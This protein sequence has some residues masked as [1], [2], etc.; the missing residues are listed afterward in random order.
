MKDGVRLLY[1]LL[2]STTLSSFINLIFY[3]N[4]S[5]NLIPYSVVFIS[6]LASFLFLFQYRLL[7][8]N[9]FEYYRKTIRDKQN[10]AIFGAGQFGILTK[11]LIDGSD[12]TNYKVVAFFEDDVRKAGKVINGT[13]IYDAK[14][15]LELALV[16]L[17]VS[18]LIIAVQNLSF[19]RKNEIVDLCLRE[20]I[21]VRAVPQV[22]D[23]VK[24]ELRL[25]HIKEI[26]IEDLLGRESIKLNN[27]IVSQQILS[28][29]VCVTGAAGSIG[30]ELVRQVIQYHPSMLILIDQ[31]ESALY[32]VERELEDGSRSVDVLTYVADIGNYSRMDEIMRTHQPEIVFH[33]AAYKH[34]PLMEK[35]PVEAVLCN[36]FGTKNIADLSVKYGVSKFVMISTDKAVNPTNV[37]GCSKRISEIYVQS[38]NNYIKT[39]GKSNTHFVTTRFG[40]VLGSNGSVIPYFKK[41]IA[42]GGPVT[43]THPEITRYFM[44]ITEACQ[45]VLEAGA[46]GQGGEIF[47]FDMGQSIKIVDLAKKMI[48]LSG[49]ELN[50]DIEIVYNGLRQGEKLYEEL[51]ASK[52]NTIQTHHAK[53]MIAKVQEYEYEVVLK[54]MDELYLA[55]S[56]NLDGYEIVKIMKDVVPEFKSN[57][58]RYTILD[59]K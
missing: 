13:R 36:V 27:E 21:K 56:N 33:A 25:N 49:L 59:E 15:N 20:N 32:E 6:F 37:M 34:V 41:Q 53:I 29:R 47:L 39:K 9:I 14:T 2:F 23:W 7:I 3:Y 44:T 10:V 35:N 40:N 12:D 26:N 30:K 46:M 11:Q 54:K 38:L 24:G 57:S 18:E 55:A 22:K 31:A 42:S 43:V 48:K 19:E 28:R 45:L 17:E 4:S 5:R 8:K 52:E 1:T 51:L 50:K 16:A 58:S